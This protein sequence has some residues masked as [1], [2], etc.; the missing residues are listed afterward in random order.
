MGLRFARSVDLKDRIGW[1]VARRPARDCGRAG[2][3]DAKP[4]SPRRRAAHGQPE[5]HAADGRGADLY[6]DPLVSGGRHRC[7]NR[8]HRVDLRSQKLL[9]GY[10]HQQPDVERAGLC[11]LVR[12]Q[13][14]PRVVGHRRRLLDRRRRQDRPPMRRFRFARPR[15]FDRRR[16]TC[17]AR[18]A[19]RTQRATLKRELAPPWSSATW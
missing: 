3:R 14:I 10:A 18:H 7:Q 6:F 8:P 1:R 19:R 13:A 4:L 17:R 9:R 11:L 16:A 2:C 15:R 12:W 5:G